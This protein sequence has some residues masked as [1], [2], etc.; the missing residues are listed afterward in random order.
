MFVVDFACVGRAGDSS[1]F[2]L[3]NSHRSR[4][5]GYDYVNDNEEDEAD[6]D[7]LIDVDVD[8]SDL[9]DFEPDD[10]YSSDTQSPGEETTTDASGVDSEDESTDSYA[11]PRPLPFMYDVSVSVVPDRC[12]FY[13]QQWKSR[14]P[15]ASVGTRPSAGRKGNASGSGSAANTASFKSGIPVILAL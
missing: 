12:I 11:G 6:N 2:S 15:V 1:P 8:D 13:G 7:D 5:N 3:T 10:A 4:E 9:L 14:D